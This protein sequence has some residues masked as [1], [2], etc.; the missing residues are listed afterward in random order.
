MAINTITGNTL[1]QCG[2]FPPCH[3]ATTG[4]NINLTTG[5]LLVVDGVVLIAGD[6]VLVKDQSDQ[7]TNGIYAA[8][9]GSWT[10]TTDATTNSQFFAGMMVTAAFGTVDAGTIFM[11]TSTDDPV[12]VGTSLIT[13]LSASILRLPPGAEIEQLLIFTQSGAG[14]VA[15]LLD[16]KVKDGAV[17]VKD[18]GA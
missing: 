10:R 2:T 15:R 5:G 7:T 3:V 14:A 9:T 8:Q 13:F 6:R 12:V 11:C 17:S 18:F 1:L 4:S 16:A